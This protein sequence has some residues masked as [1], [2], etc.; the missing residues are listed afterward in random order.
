[1]SFTQIVVISV[2][3]FVL[4]RF[5]LRTIGV[6]QLGIWALVL[7]TTS[8]TQI[9]N[10]GLSGSVVKFVAKYKSR[11]EERAISEVIQ[12]AAISVGLFSL[13]VIIIGYP[14]ARWV[15]S[16]VVPPDSLSYAL[17]ILPIALIAFWFLMMTGIFQAG[18]D[19]L[20]RIDVRSTLLMGSACL[21]LL[22]CFL[23]APLYGLIGVA[24]ARVIQNIL[25]FLIS[26]FLVRRYLKV[27]PVVPYRWSRERFNEI[28]GYGLNFQIIAITN[29]FFEPVTKALLSKF[30]GLSMVGYFEMATKMIQQF[31]AL[32]VSANQVVVPVIAEMKEK[33]PEKIQSV[34]LTSYQLMFYLAL[35]LFS[36]IIVS[37]PLISELWV[38][39][40]ER[41]FT[42]FSILLAVGWMLNTLNVPS[43]VAYLG[44]GDL[45]WNV[46]AHISI[47]LLNAALGFAGGVYFGGY[48]V[49]IAWVFS[50]ALGSSIVYVSYHLKYNIPFYELFP[51]TSRMVSVMC[52]VGIVL[53]LIMKQRLNGIFS[54][55]PTNILI[56]ITFLF[57]VFFPFWFHPMRKQL[58]RWVTDE[59]LN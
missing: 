46:L 23:L 25:V 2:V 24:Y 58:I 55:I 5:L 39:H 21:H 8:V 6:E 51:K 13:V 29:M 42:D 50:L 35:P 7:A 48:G 41:V 15:L 52:L 27:L 22:L 10:F 54:V 28:V 31:R 19:G 9:A 33:I 40:Y 38:G 37:T 26:W 53:G 32:I 57:I 17:E 1:M 56:I 20:Q 18:L 47:G 14:I 43:Y 59:I 30:G 44:I 3:L 11:D 12:T 16:M 45:R 34:Y 4:Y 49:V 36:F